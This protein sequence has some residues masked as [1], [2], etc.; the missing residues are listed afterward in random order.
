MVYNFFNKAGHVLSVLGDAIVLSVFWAVGCLPVFTIG[1]ATTA[2]YYTAH[3]TLARDR[4]YLARTFWGAFRDNFRRATPAWLVQLV[5]LVVF[6]LDIRIM[7]SVAEQGSGYRLVQYVFC[8][9]LALL[10]VWFFYTVAYQARF[11][12]TVKNNLKNAAVIAFLHPLWSLLILLVFAVVLA[13][14][15]LVPFLIFFLPAIQFLVYDVI[16]ERIFRKY[17]KPEDL[18]QELENDRID[19]V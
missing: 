9:L 3:K 2:L 13:L 14:V 18:A 7:G 12:N 8:V 11:E 1:T 5:C 4:G 16:L 19:K 6:V 17:M 10:V 15:W